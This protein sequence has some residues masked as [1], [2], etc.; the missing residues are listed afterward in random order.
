MLDTLMEREHRRGRVK[1]GQYRTCQVCNK[2]FYKPP[3][4]VKK[5]PGVTCSR[6]CCA[7]LRWRDRVQ[8]ECE[9]CGKSFLVRHDQIPKGFGRFCS[10]LCNGLADRQRATLQCR[11]CG[12]DFEVSTYYETGKKKPSYCG[13][14]CWLNCPKKFGVPHRSNIFKLKHKKL[15]LG[16]TCIRCGATKGLTLDHIIPR[17][18]GGLA[19]EENAQTLCMPCNRRKF[20]DEDLPKYLGHRR[21][22][23]KHNRV[24]VRGPDDRSQHT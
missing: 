22:H 19:T 6:A 14:E 8:R 10:N 5:W 2:Q 21:A 23:S 15:W 13:I 1:E 17:F 7:V 3:S 20:W 18:A 9:H 11:R 16:K 24:L 12:C 4:H